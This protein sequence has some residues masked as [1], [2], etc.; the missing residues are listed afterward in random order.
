MASASSLLEEEMAKLENAVAHLLRSNQEI[1]EE[2]SE[3]GRDPE[4]KTAMEENI[5]I[6]AKYRA[7]IESLREEINKAKGDVGST[8]VVSLTTDDGEEN[9]SAHSCQAS[10]LQRPPDGAVPMDATVQG[11][12]A[13]TPSHPGAMN[14]QEQ[15]GAGAGSMDVDAQG[16]QAGAE[17][18][19]WL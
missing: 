1:K 5:V 8:G 18:G 17:E 14:P 4:L 12:R 10:A 19:V 3:H 15:Q 2:L 6:I 13:S 16:N 9:N 7:R 11:P